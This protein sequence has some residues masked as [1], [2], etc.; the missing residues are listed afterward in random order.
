MHPSIDNSC[1]QPSVC[2]HSLIFKGDRPGFLLPRQWWG[3]DKNM[4]IW[5]LFG[6][7]WSYFWYLQQFSMHYI[8][9]GRNT[10]SL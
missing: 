2:R 4:K 7:N 1:C 5:K 6:R 8:Q 10:G 3:Q 9:L